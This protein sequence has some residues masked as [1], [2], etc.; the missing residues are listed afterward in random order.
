MLA[1]P[2]NAPAAPVVEF[3]SVACMKFPEIDRGAFT[4][5]SPSNS[6]V[7][8][9]TTVNITSLEDDKENLTMDAACV[10]KCFMI[11][12]IALKA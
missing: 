12:S 8:G 1:H 3:T 6:A 11:S 7:S 2:E 9:Y 5:P 4:L 10:S